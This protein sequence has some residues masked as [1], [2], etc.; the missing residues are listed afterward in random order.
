MLNQMLVQPVLERL[1]LLLNHVLGSEPVAT[2]RLQPHSGK[3]V[4]LAFEGWPVLLPP[5]PSLGFLI[6]PAGLLELQPAD[7]P[8]APDLQLRI[9][10]SNPAA[11]ALK[12]AGGGVPQ[13]HIEGD[14][15]LASEVSWLMA[16]LRW[17]VAADLERF[18]GPGVA[19]Q[20]QQFGA[21]VQKG[22]QAALAALG[23]MPK[24]P[25]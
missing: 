16:N 21:L 13:A 3:R 20:W 14:A 19:A 18:F 8:I 7:D 9:D 2:E 24:A 4:L 5:L 23:R 1:T 6:T 12:M 17:D 22:L 11:L 25:W 15:E 10:A